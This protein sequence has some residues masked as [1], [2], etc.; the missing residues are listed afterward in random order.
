MRLLAPEA[1]GPGGTTDNRRTWGR[2]NEIADLL[3]PDDCRHAGP[4]RLHIGRWPRPGHRGAAA[5]GAGDVRTGGQR[6]GQCRD[7]GARSEEHTSELQSL[8]RI[9]YAVFCLHKKNTKNDTVTPK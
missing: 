8:M 4:V 2:D 7:P 5:A 3:Q 6:R 1:P 9:S